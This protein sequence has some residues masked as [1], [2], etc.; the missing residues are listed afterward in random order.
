MSDLFD[1]LDFE[2]L[3]EDFED[4]FESMADSQSIPPSPETS[5]LLTQPASSAPQK[6]ES[7]LGTGAGLSLEAPSPA[8]GPANAEKEHPAAGG[9]D[10][11]SSETAGATAVNMMAALANEA[12]TATAQQDARTL[13]ELPPVFKYGACEEDITDAEMTFEQL[14]VE[15]EPDFLE[16]EDGKRVT[17][18][19]QYGKVTKTISSPSK[20]KIAQVKEEIEL[21][22][23]FLEGLKKARDKCPR[24]FVKP[25]V[26][27]KSKGIAA[28]K[29]ILLSPEDAAQ[30]PKPIPRRLEWRHT[31]IRRFSKTTMNYTEWSRLITTGSAENK[32]LD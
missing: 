27:G 4:P 25:T 7:G 10:G 23:E 1:N 22:K 28:Y 3:G 16:L 30:S 32:Y 15:K 18:T 20:Q 8:A 19:V 13:M 24:C 9:K 17:W 6:V 31:T 21:S 11:T 2:V 26:A 5:T 14:R 29:A 12:E